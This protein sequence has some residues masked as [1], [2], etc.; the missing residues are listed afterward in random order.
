M[1][2]DSRELRSFSASNIGSPIQI[3]LRAQ[4]HL[5]LQLLLL[6][7]KLFLDILDQNLLC[8]PL[9]QSECLGRVLQLM[10]PD[11]LFELHEADFELV[12]ASLLF[13]ASISF[14][15]VELKL[16]L[17]MRGKLILSLQ[18]VRELICF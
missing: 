11:G 5:L 6:L 8:S 9:Q 10:L 16:Y 14:D 13:E 1:R 4:R 18:N 2:L 15:L 3:R 12:H 7:L 17:F